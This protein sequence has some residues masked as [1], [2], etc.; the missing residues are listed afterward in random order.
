[1][2]IHYVFNDINKR[3]HLFPASLAYKVGKEMISLA[4]GM[5]NEQVFPFTRL[6]METKFS[7]MVLEGKDLAAAL[8]YVPSQG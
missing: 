1:M 7:N 5:P 4:E 8:Q 2:S 3:L 6:S